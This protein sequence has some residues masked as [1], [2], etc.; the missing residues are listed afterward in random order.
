[1]LQAD[2]KSKPVEMGAVW[3]VPESS[4]GKGKNV[5]RV[6]HPG[7]VQA[8]MGAGRF[9]IAMDQTP[10]LPTGG[11]LF[12]RPAPSPSKPQSPMAMQ[13]EAGVAL[14]ERFREMVR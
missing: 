14:P 11:P 8:R 6:G 3:S 10:E 2:Q 1:M 4:S 12:S 7:D 13:A 9:V 5:A